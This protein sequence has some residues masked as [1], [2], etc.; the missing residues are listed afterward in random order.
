MDNIV[1]R[2]IS[3]F[4]VKIERTMCIGSKNCVNAAPG[5]FQLDEESTCSFKEDTSNITGEVIV[6]GC[7]VCPV[8]ALHV[9]DNEGNQIVP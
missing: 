4:T 5:L 3:D 6:E 7:S 8:N 2:K 1:E 9:Y